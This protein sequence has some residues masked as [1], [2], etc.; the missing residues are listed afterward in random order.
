MRKFNLKVLVGIEACRPGK[1]VGF[2]T[3]ASLCNQLNEMQKEQ[4]LLK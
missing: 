4:Q 1:S 2:I 3:A